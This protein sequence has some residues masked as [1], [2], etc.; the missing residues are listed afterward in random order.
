MSVSKTE[1]AAACH[2]LRAGKRDDAN[3][4]A[5]M[6]EAQQAT[7]E[8][9][10]EEKAVLIIERDGAIKRGLMVLNA[11]DKLIA[12]LRTDIDAALKERP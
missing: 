6:L 10:G 12:E 9:L 2:A 11:K 5:N 1:V 4:L 8:R 7:I 3:Y